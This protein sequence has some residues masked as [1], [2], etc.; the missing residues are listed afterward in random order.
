MGLLRNQM[1]I[2]R[3]IS[4]DKVQHFYHDFYSGCYPDLRLGQA[5]LNQ[6]FPGIPDP[7]LFYTNDEKHACDLIQQYYVELVEK[8]A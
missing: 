2:H 4:P 5:F 7:D 8:A 6:F 3:R 1:T